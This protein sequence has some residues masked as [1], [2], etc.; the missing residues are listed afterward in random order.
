MKPDASFGWLVAEALERAE[1]T[2]LDPAG[3]VAHSLAGGLLLLGDAGRL[4]REQAP[5]IPVGPEFEKVSRLIRGVA[6][7]E[8]WLA[9]HAARA[10]A[11]RNGGLH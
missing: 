9:D 2:G 6:G 10:A 7:A 5:K 11:N 1:K 8:L 4:F 3:A